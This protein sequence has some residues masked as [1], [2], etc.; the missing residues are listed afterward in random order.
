GIEQRMDEA[1]AAIVAPKADDPLVIGW[2][3]INEP[4]IE[5]VVKVVPRLKGDW[6]AKRR[7]V[8][9][10]RER[11]PSIEAFN[12]AWET[13]VASF[14]AL[15]DEPLIVATRAASADMQAYF[16]LFLE[17]RYSLVNQYFR[18]YNRNHLLIGDRWMPSTANNETLVKVAGKYLDVIS[19]NYYAYGI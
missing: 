9:M 17:R 19:V 1:F 6:G 18:K 3:I 7:L 15:L 11:Y 14:E 10:L 16:E 13:Q 2:F 12:A 8:E 4:L 5:D